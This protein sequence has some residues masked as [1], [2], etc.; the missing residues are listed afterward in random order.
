MGVDIFFEG[1]IKWTLH[2]AFEETEGDRY[3]EITVFLGSIEDALT[4]GEVEV[5]FGQGDGLSS[6]G[7]VGFEFNES[8]G[9]L[10]A[11]GADIL[12]WG[13][14]GQA[15]D[16]AHGFDTGKAFFAREFNDV[17]PI[18]SAHDFN[19]MADLLPAGS[20]HMEVGGTIGAVEVAL[21]NG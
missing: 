12:N 18:F 14:A 5:F 13:R 1:I 20:F 9:E 6:D 8:V 16:F 3:N 15:G 19:E 7:I 2:L 4:V 21:D 17:V 11:V 10:L